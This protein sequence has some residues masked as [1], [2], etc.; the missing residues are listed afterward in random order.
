[1]SSQNEL[2]ILEALK[3]I[4]DLLKIQNELLEKQQANPSTKITVVGNQTAQS[5]KGLNTT[6]DFYL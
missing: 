5:T 2:H 4:R 6:E 1:M 3:E